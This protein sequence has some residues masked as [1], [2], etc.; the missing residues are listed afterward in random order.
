MVIRLKEADETP[1]H[2]MFTKSN[3]PVAVLLE[4]AFTSA[5]KN[6]MTANLVNDPGFKVRTSGTRTKM[7]VVADGDIIRNEVHRSGSTETPYRLG[8]D[9][10]TGQMFGNRDFLINCMNYLVDNNGLMDLRSREMK[11]RLLNKQEVKAKRTEWQLINILLPI[12]IV[13]IAGI[14]YSFFRK[15]KYA[16]FG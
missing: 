12:A 7:I 16:T 4:G 1:D 13:I 5:F 8:Q 14:L 9:Q 2:N 15:R 6:R 10:Y 3:L 11:L